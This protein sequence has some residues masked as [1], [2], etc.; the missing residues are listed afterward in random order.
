MHN[1]C[2]LNSEIQLN[3]VK[4]NQNKKRGIEDKKK[5]NLNIYK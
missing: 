2:I 5:A 3:P 1:P 4:V